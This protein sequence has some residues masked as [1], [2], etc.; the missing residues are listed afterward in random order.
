MARLTSWQ[1]SGT[2]A[3]QVFLSDTGT[4]LAKQVGCTKGERAGR[5]ALVIE[6]GR[7][8]YVGTDASGEIRA[9]SAEEVLKFLEQK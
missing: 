4:T 1:A 2:K 8:L 6:D 3:L 5:F 9:S 7:I